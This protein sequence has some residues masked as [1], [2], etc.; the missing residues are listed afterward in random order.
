MSLLEVFLRCFTSPHHASP[1]LV[2]LLPLFNIFHLSSPF[3]WSSDPL[4]SLN[5]LNTNHADICFAG[6]LVNLFPLAALPPLLLRLAC[7][8]ATR[9]I[10]KLLCFKAQFVE[11]RKIIWRKRMDTVRR[12]HLI[13]PIGAQ[14]RERF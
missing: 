12:S 10:A 7:Q 13:L 3:L 11:K 1:L 6:A 8:Q 14:E 4:A 2:I 5:Y 9:L